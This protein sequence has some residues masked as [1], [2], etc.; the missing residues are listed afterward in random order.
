VGGEEAAAVDAVTAWA[1]LAR[2][3]VGFVWDV[4][5]EAARRLAG[6]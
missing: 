4:L 5:V 1:D 6:R 3:L 2:T